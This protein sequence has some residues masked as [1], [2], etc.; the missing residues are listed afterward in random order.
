MLLFLALPGLGL[1]VYVLFGRDRKAFSRQ[2]KLARQDWGPTRRRCWGG[3]WRGRTARSPGSRRRARCASGSCG[4]CGATPIPLLTTRNR[5][6]IQQDASVH[7]PSLMEDLKRA[8]R[9]IHL[10]YYIWAAT[11][12]REELKAILLERAASGVEVRLLYDPFGSFFGSAAATGGSWRGR[13]AR[14]AGLGAVAAAHDLLPQP[15]QDRRHRRAGRLHRRHEHRPGAHRRRVRTFDRWRDTQVRLEGE[16]AAVLQAVFLVDW[17]NAT[18]EDLFAADQ[19]PSLG[20]GAPAG[21]RGCGRR[22]PRAGPDPDLGSGLGMARHPPALFRHDHV[23][24]APR[25]AAI[26]LLHPRCDH[27]RGAQGGGTGRHRRRGDGERPR[28]GAEP[29][30]VL[31]RQHLPGRGRGRRGAGA[32]V[33]QGLSACQ[34]AQHRRRGLLRSAR[35]TSTSAASAS[36]TSSTP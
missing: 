12:S 14:R 16:G 25:A 13:R 2:R 17:Y 10:Q 23:G 30:A 32:H 4:W 35:P 36:T 29:D 1:A 24:P 22:W 15:P 34:D 20:D 31:G 5:V 26:P 19:F 3:S 9:S 6:A 21:G 11:R 8:R 18:G 27:R 28:R 7:Y 33:R